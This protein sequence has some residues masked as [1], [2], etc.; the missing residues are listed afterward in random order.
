MLTGVISGAVTG[1]VVAIVTG[2]GTAI[3]M[4]F[5]M[6]RV[7]VVKFKSTSRNNVEGHV[8]DFPNAIVGEC[9]L[10]RNPSQ[11]NPCGEQESTD[12]DYI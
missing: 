8:Y 4:Y 11:V 6:R 3:L 5:I 9:E 2:L 12:N 1:V 10:M 7:Q